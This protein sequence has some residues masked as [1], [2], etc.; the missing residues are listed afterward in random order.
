MCCNPQS[1]AEGEDA[2]GDDNDVDSVSEL[3]DAEGEPGLAT[4]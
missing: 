3:G 1:L 4:N 2:H